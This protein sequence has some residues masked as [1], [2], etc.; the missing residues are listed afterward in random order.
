MPCKTME[1]KEQGIAS[2]NREQPHKRKERNARETKGGN[3]IPLPLQLQ[4]DAKFM[5]LNQP[6][7]Q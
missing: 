2:R 5:F 4:N 3:A 6:S 7:T 1:R